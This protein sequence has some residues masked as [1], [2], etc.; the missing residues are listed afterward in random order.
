[1]G[2]T[3]HTYPLD[4]PVQYQGSIQ[5][6]GGTM[7]TFYFSVTVYNGYSGGGLGG[8]SRPRPM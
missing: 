8:G 6:F 1:M 5:C 4:Y 3:P 7:A 2:V